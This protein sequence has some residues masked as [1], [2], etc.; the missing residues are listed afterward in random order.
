M[1]FNWFM[2]LPPTLHFEQLFG[3]G[4][5]SSWKGDPW[6][7][8]ITSYSLGV[9]RVHT[10]KL[11]RSIYE[12]HGVHWLE[13]G[14]GVH[15]CIYHFIY[16]FIELHKQI[17]YNFVWRKHVLKLFVVTFST[18][19]VLN[20][21]VIIIDYGPFLASKFIYDVDVV[22]RYHISHGYFFLFHDCAFK[23]ILWT[24]YVQWS[25][26]FIFFS[27]NRDMTFWCSQLD[28]L[29]CLMGFISL[30]KSLF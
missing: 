30:V 12:V 17:H 9:A 3:D 14:L 10:F 4:S 28:C 22:A 18:H 20:S 29:G 23:V 27:L 11:L 5:I 6:P 1:F 7:S 24:N 21:F 15:K 25:I 2:K 8:V 19:I 26:V 16:V 13:Y